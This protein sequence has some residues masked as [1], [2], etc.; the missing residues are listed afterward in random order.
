MLENEKIR[1]RALEPED[2]EIL[3]RW[4]NDTSLWQNGNTLA[5]WSRFSLRKYI[6]ESFLSI[7]E[8]KQV[9]LIIVLQETNEAVGAV[10]LFNFD[11]YHQRAETGILIDKNFRKRGLGE[12]TLH[13]I[14]EYAFDFLKIK[15]LY[16][17]IPENNEISLRLFQR[18][19]YKISGKLQ[20]W[21]KS[22]PAFENV[23]ILQLIE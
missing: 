13:L 19:G 7:Y 1:L 6:E 9:R 18:C 16:A 5:P 17:H 10:D 11:P 2:I 3:Y 22:G 4:E 23:Y 14:R 20:A 8:I 15:Q 12:Q 21:L